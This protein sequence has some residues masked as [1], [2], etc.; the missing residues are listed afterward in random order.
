MDDST[1]PDFLSPD[2]TK[3]R[4]KVAMQVRKLRGQKPETTAAPAATGPDA[5]RRMKAR[6]A[7]LGAGKQADDATIDTF[8][9]NNPNFK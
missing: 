6:Q 9:K 5:E 1:P 4:G 7:L 8:L 3:G 2:A